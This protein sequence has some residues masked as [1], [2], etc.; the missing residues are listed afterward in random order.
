MQGKA[1]MHLMYGADNGNGRAALRLYQ[2][3]FPNRR[4]PKNTM[5]ERLHRS[6]CENGS[7]EAT[8]DTRSGR[9]ARQPRIKES[10]LNIVHESPQTST[11]ATASRLQLNHSTVWRVLNENG[12]HPYRLQRVQA[13]Q[14]TD[15]SLRVHFCHWFLQQCE[16]QANFPSDALFRDEATFSQDGIFSRYN[17]HV[18]STKNPHGTRPREFQNS[19]SVNVWAGIVN[20]YLIGPYLLPARS[21]GF[22]Y[23]IF[24]QEVLP[25]LLQDV[26][27]VVRDRMWFQHD[28][29]PAHNHVRVCNYLDGTFPGR[30]MG[31]GGPVRWPPNSP[32]L[33]SLDFFLLEEHHLRDYR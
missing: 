9:T 1:D 26:P 8:S 28:G 6:L 29:A 21:N 24:L 4:M 33:R 10:I 11:R 31:R 7:L 30:W 2:E 23:R 17:M 3:R 5:F 32:D 19:F 25:E 12:L 20:D 22:C 13:L 18:W 14:N 27:A 15:Y 16:A